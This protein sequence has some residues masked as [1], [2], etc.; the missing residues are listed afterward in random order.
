MT[1]S[2]PPPRPAKLLLLAL[3]MV[4]SVW[5]VVPVARAGPLRDWLATRQATRQAEQAA[6]DEDSRPLNAVR[7]IRDLAYGNDPRQ[8]L[9][10]YLPQSPRRTGPLIVL[11]HGGAW[12]IGDKASASVV[13]NKV[14]HWSAQGAVLVSVNYRML[15]DTGPLEQARDV[16]RALLQAQQQAA[17]WG[18]D[19]HRTILVGHSAGAHLVA[20]LNSQPALATALT[21]TP[22]RA[23]V[24]LDSAAF[25]IPA[26]MQA[27]H[28][29]FYDAAFGDDPAYWQQTSP[30]HALT[31]GAPPLLAVCSTLRR[32]ACA[33]AQ[34]FARSARTLGNSVSVLEQPLSHHDINSRLGAD[35]DYTAAVDAFLA[36]ADPAFAGR[37]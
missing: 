3:A 6:P 37:P 28:A 11:V 30:R 31:R 20:L 5:T 10:A 24:A 35:P 1:I 32:Q 19:R 9:D 12:R 26:L 21:V 13:Q 34:Q 4:S 25:D 14:A 29:R 27:P 33:Q 22:W 15:P 18:A 8:R 2:P 23:T 16:A 7:V 36:R 17:G